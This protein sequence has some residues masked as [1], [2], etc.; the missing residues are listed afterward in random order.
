M[1]LPCID[2]DRLHTKQAQGLV[3]TALKL[4]EVNL[5]PVLIGVIESA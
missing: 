1:V 5:S 2:V 3:I 4:Q